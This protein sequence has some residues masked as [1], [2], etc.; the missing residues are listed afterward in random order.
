M[1]RRLSRIPTMIT[2]WAVLVG[3]LALIA[4]PSAKAYVQCEPNW[5]NY[6]AGY[7]HDSSTH[8][9]SFEGASGYLTAVS[10]SVC[11]SDLSGPNPPNYTI[12][13]NFTTAWVMIADY[14]SNSWSQV[15]VIRGYSTPMYVWAEVVRNSPGYP[16][17]RFDRFRGEIANGTRRAYYEYYSNDCT[18]IQSRFSLNSVSSSELINQTNFNPFSSWDDGGYYPPRW[19]PQYA[20]EKT[21]QASNILGSSGLHVSFQSIGAQQYS[22]DAYIYEP[23]TL[24]GVLTASRASRAPNGC[25]N[26]D[27]WTNS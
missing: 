19:S 12:G 7:Y 13:S 21:Y 22:N 9:H 18:C 3:G 1:R 24:T 8:S 17:I 26:F 15:G 2:V 11:D 23:C 14:F 27:V 6:F 4:A 10:N 25:Y 20:A 16:Y 5:G